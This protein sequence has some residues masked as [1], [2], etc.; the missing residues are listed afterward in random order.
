M[1]T[2]CCG[3]PPVVEFVNRVFDIALLALTVLVAAEVCCGILRGDGRL[4]ACSLQFLAD[5]DVAI[6]DVVSH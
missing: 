1:L 6:T 3:A 5:P 2:A 4:D